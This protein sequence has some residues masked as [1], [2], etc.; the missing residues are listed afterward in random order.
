M[1]GM[2]WLIGGFDEWFVWCGVKTQACVMRL[3]LQEL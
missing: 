2:D 3:V 1:V